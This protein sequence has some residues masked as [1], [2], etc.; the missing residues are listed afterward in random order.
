LNAEIVDVVSP[1]QL[2]ID[3]VLPY[4]NVSDFFGVKTEMECLE[5]L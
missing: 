2:Y 5:T 3:D 4:A 1:T